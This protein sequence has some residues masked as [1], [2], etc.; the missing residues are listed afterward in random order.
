MD[1]PLMLTSANM[2]SGQ[3]IFIIE[4]VLTQVVALGAWFLIVDFPDRA[5]KKGL[6]SFNEAT[7]IAQ[8]IDRDR[9]DA[10]P[11]PLTKAKFILH[12]KDPKMWAFAIM[13]MSTTVPAYALAYF[14][15]L[16]TRKVG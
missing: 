8:R 9:G 1:F 7:F 10:T 3:W 14:G 12:L 5:E 13:F 11:D 4:G 2:K 6:L 16:E 15:Q